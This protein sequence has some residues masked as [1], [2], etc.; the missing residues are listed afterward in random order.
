MFRLVDQA[1]DKI[2][3]I[4]NPVVQLRNEQ[5]LL[6]LSLGPL[7]DGLV[8][9]TQ[10]DFEQG[11]AQALSDVQFCFRPFLRTA[12]YG[13]LPRFKALSWREAIAIRTC[14]DRFFRIARPYDRLGKRLAPE[15]QIIARGARYGNNQCPRRA[16]GKP[17]RPRHSFRDL[18]ACQQPARRSGIETGYDGAEFFLVWGRPT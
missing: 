12:L 1:T 10:N 13:F 5:F 7:C 3:D 18:F 4:A 11:D 6:L 9:Q 17:R 8:G 14:F 16:I 15:D 2:E